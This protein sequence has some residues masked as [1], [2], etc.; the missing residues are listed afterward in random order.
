MEYLERIRKNNQYYEKHLDAVGERSEKR[1][2][3]KALNSFLAATNPMGIL[4]DIGCGTG[5][6]L[7]TFKEHK[8][9]AIGIEPC[10]QMREVCQKKGLETMEGCF[11]NLPLVENISGVWCASSLLHVPQENFS[12]VLKDLYHMLNPQGTLFYT[13]RLGCKAKW[14]RYDDND[15][16]AE[17]FIQLFEKE[18]LLEETALAGFKDIDYWVE[19]SYWGRPSKWL[20]LIAKK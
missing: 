12:L 17:R 3:S 18:F 6:H 16:Q 1:D 4:L 7:T 2:F 5:N 14:D 19:D 9:R 13:V 8:R 10:A 20:S 15:Q 11:E